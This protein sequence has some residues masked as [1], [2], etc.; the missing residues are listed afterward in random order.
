MTKYLP[1]AIAVAVVGL[2]LG[3]PPSSA[4]TQWP[5]RVVRFIV[6]LGPGA[7]V[8]ITGRLVADRLAQ[9]WGQSVV[10]DNKPGGDGVVAMTAFTS[11]HDTHT[12]LLSPTS[13]FTHHPWTLDKLPY[14]P[15]DLVP[16][17]RLTNT[18]VSIVVASSSPYNSLDELFKAIQANPG[19][20]NQANI[21]GFFDFVFTGFQKAHGMVVEHV[22]YRNTVQAANDLSEGRIQ[23]LMSAIAIVRPLVDA[24]KIKMLAVTA[25]RRAATAPNIATVAELG[26]PDL[27][28]DGLVGLFGPRELPAEV[29][30]RI[31]ADVKAVLADPLV[32]KRLEETGQVINFGGPAEFSASIDKQRVQAAAAGKLLG[33]KPAEM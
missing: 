12:L 3:T 17:A 7:G 26:Y 18:V 28:I 30:E 1:W 8:D 32:V 27:T 23:L 19:K 5:Q 20:F 10:I 13:A 15:H 2:V 21:T 29:R 6:P 25:S 24:G 33:I 22:P 31:A 16:V 9:K 11:S 14:D 4:Q